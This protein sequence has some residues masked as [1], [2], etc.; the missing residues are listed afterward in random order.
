MQAVQPSPSYEQLSATTSD[1]AERLAAYMESEAL[2]APSLPPPPLPLHMDPEWCDSTLYRCK[3]DNVIQVDGIGDDA[4]LHSLNLLRSDNSDLDV[5]YKDVPYGTS[6]S[7]IDL[8]LHEDDQNS[9]GSRRHSLRDQTQSMHNSKSSRKHL[10]RPH[11]TPAYPATAPA[12]QP[13]SHLAANFRRRLS[14]RESTQHE[15]ESTRPLAWSRTEGRD[16]DLKFDSELD[17]DL[18]TALQ[19]INT[20]RMDNQRATPPSKLLLQRQ[21]TR[22]RGPA[23]SFGQVEAA[24]NGTQSSFTRHSAPSARSVYLSG[25]QEKANNLDEDEDTCRL[26]DELER[27]GQRGLNNQRANPPPRL[28]LSL[29]THVEPEMQQVFSGLPVTAPAALA[30][31]PASSTWATRQP[32]ERNL[33]KGEPECKRSEHRTKNA[34]SHPSKD[35]PSSTTS[36]LPPGRL[37]R[38]K[39]FMARRL[40]HLL[41]GSIKSGASGPFSSAQASTADRPVSPVSPSSPASPRDPYKKRRTAHVGLRWHSAFPDDGTHADSVKEQGTE[42]TGGSPN[43]I[44]PNGMGSVTST[45]Q[46]VL[47]PDAPRADVHDRTMTDVG[48]FPHSVNATEKKARE[49]KKAL[50]PQVYVEWQAHLQVLLLLLWAP[51]GATV[52]A[53]AT[54]HIQGSSGPILVQVKSPSSSSKVSGHN[55]QQERGPSWTGEGEQMREDSLTA[56]IYPPSLTHFPAQLQGKVIDLRGQGTR[57][58]PLETKILCVPDRS[59]RAMQDAAEDRMDLPSLPPQLE[60]CACI[61]CSAPLLS[62]PTQSRFHLGDGSPRGPVP[63]PGCHDEYGSRVREDEEAKDVK[64][65]RRLLPLPAAGWEE[66]VDAW[67]CHEDQ[68]INRTVQ[69]GKDVLYQ[70]AQGQHSTTHT[71]HVNTVFASEFWIMPQGQ[72]L[73]PGAVTWIRGEKVRIAYLTNALKVKRHTSCCR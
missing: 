18:L 30:S 29:S 37:S 51:D 72:D 60:G 16:L 2:T 67:M 32:R 23:C 56:L 21:K 17:S 6:A 68:L 33:R 73:L 20:S 58:H 57:S 40:S 50:A 1:E 38:G 24:E 70:D 34:F 31:T 14:D 13:A 63:V 55:Q 7:Y 3:D 54:A 71:P 36:K 66:L 61:Q 11:S 64:W 28:P 52:P 47:N 26:L 12:S 65:T 4:S 27:A 10:V 9:I 53:E 48:P 19:S 44:L 59:D 8:E 46:T 35:T 15:T 45:S 41:P 22:T 25:T 62:P 43:Q 39:S 69:R 42:T 49:P 5:N